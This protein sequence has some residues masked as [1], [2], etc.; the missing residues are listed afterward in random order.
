MLRVGTQGPAD[1]EKHQPV[2]QGG[3]LQPH[4]G[5][6]RAETSDEG[7]DP[8]G[9]CRVGWDRGEGLWHH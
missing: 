6:V 7:A 8:G 3:P 9:V 4:R 5:H 2:V 1:L